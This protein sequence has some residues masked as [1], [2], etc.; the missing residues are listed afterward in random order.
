[1]SDRDTHLRSGDTLV[2]FL[3]EYAVNGVKFS[4][5][6][7]A[8]DWDMAQAGCDSRRPGELVIG[9]LISRVEVDLDAS[10][11]PLQRGGV[12]KA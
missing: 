8:S 10:R 6:I 5:E 3:T 9:R 1:M 12:A 11:V 7:A 2:C 4:D